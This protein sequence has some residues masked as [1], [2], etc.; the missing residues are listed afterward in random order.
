MASGGKQFIE[1]AKAVRHRAVDDG[2]TDVSA[3]LS[4]WAFLS[5]FPAL[6]A[7]VSMIGSMEL[8]VG[9]Q[10]ADDTRRSVSD[11]LD[12][13]LAGGPAEKI[14]DSVLNVINNGR[15]GLAIVAIAGAL[16][17]MSKG[18]AGLA[19]ALALIHDQPEARRG[20][21][22]RLVGLGLG[23]GTIFVVVLVLLQSVL[24][25]LFGFESRLP[26]QGSKAFLYIWEVARWP[27]MAALL[28]VWTAVM[29]K[30]GPGLRVR[31]RAVLPGA[32][33]TTVIWALATVGFTLAIRLG[34]LNI[35]PIFGA[36]GGVLLFLSWLNLMSMG[37]LIGAEVDV[38]RFRSKAPAAIAAPTVAAPARQ[39]QSTSPAGIALL[40]AAFASRKR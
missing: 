16:W 7:V 3:G 24:G 25:P 28:V 1:T 15:G 21:R 14:R 27:V 35:N 10:T 36:I 37:I 40:V 39:P 9:R 18:F 33:T 22:G 38:V 4:F 2:L 5:I 32:L 12:R 20:F 34:L 8:F 31:L 19:R 17:S 23:T 30:Y 11:Y 29:L 26:K 6:L 13:A